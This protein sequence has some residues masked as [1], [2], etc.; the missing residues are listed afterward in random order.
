MRVI[1]LGFVEFKTAWQ[2]S[3][4]ETVGSLADLTATLVDILREER[5]RREDDELPTLA[6]VPIMKRMEFKA[7]G[8]PTVQAGLL[9]D[10]I[11]DV[12]AEELLVLAE[13]RRIALEEA[14]EIDRLGD[15]MP[16]LPPPLD[17]S[18]IGT[19][20]EVCWRYWRAPTAVEIAKGEKRK[21]IGVPIWCEGEVVLVANG[22]TTTE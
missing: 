21:K 1:G 18:I 4:D 6:V 22:T 13:E 20:L 15:I 8:D 12:P 3:K 16:P 5:E 14:G 2:S 9:A 7:L 19:Q 17:D 10:C 11:K